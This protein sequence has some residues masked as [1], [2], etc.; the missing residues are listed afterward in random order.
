MSSRRIHTLF[1]AYNRTWVS[2]ILSPLQYVWEVIPLRAQE[3][4]IASWSVAEYRL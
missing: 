3:K 1:F 2:R 4:V